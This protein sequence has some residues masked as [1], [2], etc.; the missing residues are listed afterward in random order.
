MPP[1]IL[2][3]DDDPDLC[4]LVAEALQD[5]GYQVEQAHDGVMAL[6]HIAAHPPDLVLTDV[7]MPRL[8]GLDLAHLL[9]A[10][11]AR[12][13]VMLMSA[14]PPPPTCHLPVLR[15]P[16]AV[17]TLLVLIAR[18]LPLSPTDVGGWWWGER[19]LLGRDAGLRD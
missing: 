4:T 9:A 1:T 17:E 16:F 13:P 2:V 3:V 19:P 5:A 15:K 18:T 11:P 14:S 12:I 8:D 7:R 6:D 10:H